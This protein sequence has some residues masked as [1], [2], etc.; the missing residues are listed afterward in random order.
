LRPFVVLESNNPVSLS[1]WF[2]R[3]LECLVDIEG[4]AD[5]PMINLLM[6]Y[7]AGRW[8]MI[9]FPRSKHRPGRYYAEGEERLLISPGAVDMAGVLVIPREEDYRRVDATILTEIYQEV[10]LSEGK[11]LGFVNRLAGK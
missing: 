9:L 6:A 10:T 8:Q 3:A 1:Q 11:F 7:K 4:T 2:V 5:E